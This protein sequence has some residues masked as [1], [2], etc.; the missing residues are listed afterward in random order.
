MLTAFLCEIKFQKAYCRQNHYD[1]QQTK[2]VNKLKMKL[3]NHI[4]SYKKVNY[5][6]IKII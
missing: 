6:I 2:P 5:T 1:I 4:H 3:F